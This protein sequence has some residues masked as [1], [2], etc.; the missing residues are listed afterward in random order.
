MSRTYARV[1]HEVVDDP[2]FA[3]V[4]GNDAALATWLRMLLIADAMWPA[5]APMP[6]KTSAV[7]LLIEVGLIAERA[8]NRYVVTG[9]QAERERRSAVGRNA[10]DVRWQNERNANAMPSKA[11]QNRTEHSNG[12]N[13][14]ERPAAFLAMRPKV[15]ASLDDIRRQ[16]AEQWSKCADCGKLGREHSANSEH[17]FTV[18]V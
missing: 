18:A 6:R 11:E 16:E 1:Y 13:A 12:A 17:K 8:G 15:T 2:K 10:A 3:R 4:Y 7:R 9:L 14:P 5:S